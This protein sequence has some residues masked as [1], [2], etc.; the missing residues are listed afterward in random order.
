[1]WFSFL[2][3]PY[4]HYIP[5]EENL[6]DLVDKIKWCIT[7]DDKCYDIAMNGF[8][9][10][11]KYLEK[12]GIYDYMQ[13][14]LSK[15]T[16]TSLNLKKYDKTIALITVYKNNKDNTRLIQ[17]RYFLYMMNKLL[18]QICN[19]DIIVVEQDEN[20][21]FNIGKLKNIGFDYLN[22]NSS[23]KYDNYIF[24][25]ID[26]IPNTDL[27]DYF[28]KITDS[29]NA[30]GTYGTRYTEMDLKNN[31]PFV[32]ALISCTKEFF[33]EINGYPNN[34]YG[35]QG[36]DE[37]LLLRLYET[38]KPLYKNKNGSIIDTEITNGMLKTTKEKVE[39][40]NKEKEDR[41]KLVYEKNVNYKNYKKNGL[42]N[43]NYDV[44]DKFTFTNNYHII[45]NL[46]KEE[47]IKLY[48]N[49]Y[50]FNK[51]IEKDEYKLIKKKILYDIKQ[52][53]F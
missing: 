32:G 48:P 16:P 38:K 20:Y 33:E 6:D 3:K 36:E 40:L 15:I 35:W 18:K 23:K 10:Y 37:N 42:S 51:S 21:P 12:D 34:F 44:I 27:I 4:E 31:I 5:I 30:L 39:E 47:S 13:N 24:S 7:N 29:L 2:L 43:L 17:K 28:F 26:T 50:I 11:K 8:H 14:I 49:D 52:V 19:Y 45:V 9:F 46:K 41:E 22:K 25:D 53:Y 1:M